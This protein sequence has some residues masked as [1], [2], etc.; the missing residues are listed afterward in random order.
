MGGY[1]KEKLEIRE[2]I[3]RG[4]TFF[5]D[6]E[7][8]QPT[9][10]Y[11]KKLKFINEMQYYPLLRVDFDLTYTANAKMYLNSWVHTEDITLPYI[12]AH[13]L[14]N[15]R[16]II[17]CNEA[18]FEKGRHIIRQ[19]LKRIY[20]IFQKGLQPEVKLIKDQVWHKYEGRKQKLR[21]YMNKGKYFRIKTERTNYFVPTT[22]AINMAAQPYYYEIEGHTTLFFS[23]NLNIDNIKQ[24]IDVTPMLW[25][26][27]NYWPQ[28]D[29][30]LFNKKAIW[31]LKDTI[32]LFNWLYNN[33]TTAAGSARM[34]FA[35]KEKHFLEWKGEQK[36]KVEDYDETLLLL[37]EELT[38]PTEL[39]F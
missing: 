36:I 12:R 30:I 16:D 35:F 14:F 17:K 32:P 4:Q 1:D 11:A 8:E 7:C 5:F 38:D 39:D 9:V 31:E 34:F 3:I 33:S 15:G 6:I 28:L 26:N 21:T 29:F 19:D 22:Q 20:S 2:S 23:D 13:G 27:M 37:I 18:Q 10:E 25:S 24:C